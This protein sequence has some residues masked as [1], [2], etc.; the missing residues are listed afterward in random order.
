MF[1]YIDSILYV[2]QEGNSE[3]VILNK[4]TYQILQYIVIAIRL[5]WL[6]LITLSKT[7]IVS[8]LISW[9]CHDMKTLSASRAKAKL[10]HEQ[11]A[12]T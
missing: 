9:W 5:V 4:I 1:M 2:I 11:Y 8:V 10:V 3:N 12:K 7:V 6:L